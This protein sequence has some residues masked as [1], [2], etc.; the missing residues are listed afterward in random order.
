VTA[1]RRARRGAG[2]L[3]STPAAS[4][5]NTRANLRRAALVTA[6]LAGVALGAWF[7]RG[8]RHPPR[9][10]P[11]SAAGSNV[12]LITIDTLRA[13]RVGA[14]GNPSGL[15]PTLDRLAGSGLRFD[16]AFTPVP[17]TLPAHASILTGLEPFSHGIRNNTA[18]R[19]GETPTLATMLKK[20]GYRTGAFVGAFVL[21]ARFG[22]N[23][24]FDEYDD[25][26]GHGG[27]AADFHVAERPAERVIQ[28]ATEWILGKAPATDPAPVGTVST[29]TTEKP[30]RAAPWFAWVHLYDP[31]APYQAPPEYRRGRSPYDAE[32][33]YTDAMIG[34]GL[35]AL[36]A[37]G[38]L[39]RTI[40]IVVGDHGEALGEHGESSHGLFAYGSTLRVPMIVSAPGI[41]P[42]V[43][44]TPVAHVDVVPTVLELLGMSI[45]SGLDGRSLLGADDGTNDSRAFYFEALDAN[46]TRGWAPLVGVMADGWKYID[47]PIPELYD[48]EHDPDEAHNLATRDQ[49]RLRVL[50]ARLKGVAGSRKPAPGAARAAT[51]AETTQRLASLGYVGSAEPTGKRTFSE[52]DDPKNLVALNESFYTAIRDQNNGQSETAL[53][54]L[55]A[56]VAERPD[57]LAARRSAAAIQSALGRPAESIELLQSAPGAAASATVQAEL[58]L[59]LE[60]QG[61]LAEAATYLETAVR[62]REGDLET[63]NSLAV[64]Y[65]RLRRFEDGRRLFRQVI[66]A[67]PHATA[68]WNNLG[69]LEMSAGD[70]R[71]AADAFQHAVTADPGYGAAWQG[72][73]AALVATDAAGATQAWQRAVVLEPRDYDSLFNLGIVLSERPEPREALPYLKRFVAE[74]PRDRY[75]R[76]IARGAALITRIERR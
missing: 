10:S 45:P 71:A 27:D 67:D 28:P 68:T 1:R 8:V 32:V 58:G 13:D 64:V 55:R 37:A 21:N 2:R 25:R 9:I 41:R 34:R 20:A 51:D 49:E 4:S 52:A 53:R 33:A 7:I 42:H 74:A 11:G 39:D 76:D 50:Q 65:A 18:F 5:R 24:D 73:G 16:A 63:I 3:S 70:R 66:D 47:L 56:V 44:R 75:V 23:R 29:V 46:L 57:F 15:T 61:H 43:V 26:C 12:L 14:Y 30:G 38:Q 35:D 54:E 17:M 31:H 19:L 72:L 69:I 62:L 60:G 6:L 40:V 59:V 36:R 22:L 48:L